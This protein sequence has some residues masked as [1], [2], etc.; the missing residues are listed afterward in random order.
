VSDADQFHGKD[1]E[2]MTREDMAVVA[3]RS[4]ALLMAVWTLASL[5]YVPEEVFSLVYH[6]GHQSA[7]GTRD[8]WSSLHSLVI[9]FHVIR[10]LLTA[11]AGIWVWKGGPVPQTL[12]GGTIETRRTEAGT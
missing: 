9:T 7:V 2:E 6:L 10:L 1:L 5:T 8:H 12:F 4:L 11:L 3:S